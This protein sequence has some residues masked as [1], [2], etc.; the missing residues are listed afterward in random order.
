MGVAS[1][2][3]VIKGTRTAPL[4]SVKMAALRAAGAVL[5]RPRPGP[6]PAAVGYHK[7]VRGER[8]TGRDGGGA[9]RPSLTLCLGR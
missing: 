9:G 2:P 8:D 3:E 1:S 4:P 6:A 5:L 7:K